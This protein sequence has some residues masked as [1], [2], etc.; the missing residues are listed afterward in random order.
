LSKYS[1]NEVSHVLGKSLKN[2]VLAGVVKRKRDREGSTRALL[3][4]AIEVF[5]QSGY[6]AATTRAVAKKAGVSEGLIQRYFDGKAGLLLAILQTFASE[7]ASMGLA[8]LP[9]QK[10]L[11]EEFIA[12]LTQDCE[13]HRAHSDFIKV[14]M[15]RAIVDP[16]IGHQLRTSVHEKKLPTVVARLRHYQ[17]AGLIAKDADLDAI[18][19][20]LSSIAFSVGFMGPQVFGYDAQRMAQYAKLL[21]SM[22]AKGVQT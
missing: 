20:G 22:L 11:E 3:E 8:N 19:Y 12:V 1:L 15:S 2:K 16:K 13:K 7:E 17:E 18:A 10:T 4:A 21:A 5:S 9:Y 14:A 6:D